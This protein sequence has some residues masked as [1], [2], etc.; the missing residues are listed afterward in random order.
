MNRR[1]ALIAGGLAAVSAV[2]FGRESDGPAGVKRLLPIGP[3]VSLACALLPIEVDLAAAGAPI[4]Q[5]QVLKFW[6]SEVA[7]TLARWDFDLQVFD[8]FNLPQ[9]VYAWQLRRSASGLA[10]PSNGVKM[11]FPLGARMDL[12]ATVLA[13][14]G[15]AQV[16]N[17]SVPGASLMVLATARQLSGSP[18]ELSDL[19]YDAAKSLLYM[20][21]GSRRDF[22]ALLLRTS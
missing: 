21:D 3:P 20:A 5:L 19:R 17:A 15:R 13:R 22:D 11:C 1:Q 14:S 4:S 12:S 7:T 10:M 16:F 8:Q 9:W 18:P 6:P 2:A